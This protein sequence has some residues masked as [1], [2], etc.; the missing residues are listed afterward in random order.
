MTF[1]KIDPADLDSRNP[2]GS[3]INYFLSA[4]IRR[5]IQLYSSRNDF[6]NNEGFYSLTNN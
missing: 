1:T 3:L 5:P 2:S 6:I 4:R